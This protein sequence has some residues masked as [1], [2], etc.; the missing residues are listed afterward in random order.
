MNETRQMREL[1]ARQLDWEAAHVGYQRAVADFPLA[2]RGVVPDGFAHSGWQMVE[3]IRLAQADILDFCVNPAYVAPAWPESYWPAAAPQDA[4]AWDASVEGYQRD[5]EALRQL[6]L[7]ENVDLFAPIPWGDGQ[8]CL[9]E[10]LLVTD[11]TS[12]HVGQL[13]AL[14]RA[15]GCWS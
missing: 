11:H 2:L 12:Y 14:Q 13:V 15:L 5:L 9:R 3:H 7:D 4:A 6:A 1:L 8:T 10:L